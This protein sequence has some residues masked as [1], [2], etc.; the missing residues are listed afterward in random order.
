MWS[1]WV[2][3]GLASL[4]LYGVMG[5]GGRR[6]EMQT[7]SC[8]RRRMEML[9]WQSR[10][11]HTRGKKGPLFS[12]GLYKKEKKR[13][14]ASTSGSGCVTKRRRAARKKTPLSMGE[15]K[16][17]AKMKISKISSYKGRQKEIE[18][19]SARYGQ[20]ALA[21]MRNLGKSNLDG[22]NRRPN[23]LC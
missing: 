20:G 5:R 2:K 8:R 17:L 21:K 3:E 18:W 16:G 9:L 11:I 22:R 19:L 4:L 12:P 10:P 7:A 14:S 15:C 23:G 6:N 1:M 13:A